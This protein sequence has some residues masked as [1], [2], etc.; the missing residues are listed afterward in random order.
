MS[1]NSKIEWT[2]ATWNPVSGCSK[3]SAGCKN[4]YAERIS[5]RWWGSREFTDV[6]LHPERLDW[7]LQWR[8]PRRIF[9]NSMSDLFH[10]K[11]T[12]EFIG[13]VIEVMRLAKHHTFQVLTKRPDRM[14]AMMKSFPNVW[15][16]VSIEDQATADERIPLLLNTEASVR[17]ISAEPLLGP[18]DLLLA[19]ADSFSSMAGIHWVIAGGES[20]PEA[21]PMHP[22]WV[23]DIRDQCLTAGVPFFFKQYGSWGPRSLR[24]WL[25]KNRHWFPTPK[26]H[27]TAVWKN[28]VRLNG[29]LLDGREWN[30][31]PKEQT[32]SVAAK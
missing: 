29:R 25:E 4:C 28:P 6:Q 32:E 8:K 18:V 30:E 15:A 31:F 20:G 24:D 21:R 10:P 5:R 19:A 12:D 26:P 9:V 11:V 22:D 14:R 2:D 13:K 16:G 3:V 17:F 1:L 27:G 7:P 23:R